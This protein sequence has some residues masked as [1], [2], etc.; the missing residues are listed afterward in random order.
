MRESALTPGA[1]APADGPDYTPADFGSD[2]S[3]SRDGRF[4]AVGSARDD[5]VGTGVR[6]PPFDSQ[7][8]S[9]AGAVY[10]FERRPTGWRLREFIKANFDG[11]QFLAFGAAVSLARNGKDL[12][13]GAPGDASNA[14]GIDGDQED[15][16]APNRG[17]V[18]LY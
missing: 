12:A 13:V 18:W 11:V 16:S 15:T 3:L 8:A 17:A 4:L 1:W 14:L 10:V 7:H 6:Y 5:A 9:P 2:L